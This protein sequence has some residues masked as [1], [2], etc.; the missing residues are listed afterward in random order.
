MTFSGAIYN[1]NTEIR[2]I[3]FDWG[4]VITDLHF[5]KTKQAFL[6]LGLA[7]WDESVPHDPH[8]DLF[9]PFEIGN[10]SPA[11]FRDRVRRYCT[12]HISDESIDNA[13]NAMLGELPEERWEILKKANKLYQTFLLSN[14][15]AIHLPY[16]F[17]RIREM[18]GIYGYGH[19]FKK[20]YFSYELGLRKPNADIFKFVVKDAGIIPGE[21]MFIDDF[22]ENIDT[23]RLMGFQTIHLM[24]PLTLKDI[25]VF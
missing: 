22:I 6:D 24:S 11:Q 3:I 8:D 21:T 7:I 12:H 17:E 14:T 13:W 2:N 18:Y 5:E 10:I 16:Y 19:L 15:N 23:A 1:G 4:G 20:T 25:F 9:I